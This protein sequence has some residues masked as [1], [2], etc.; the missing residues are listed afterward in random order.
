M[1]WT[2][3]LTALIGT[4]GIATVLIVLVTLTEKKGAAMLENAKALAESYKQLA[5]EYQQR[6]AKTQ[7][8]LEAKEGELLNQIKMNSSLRHALDDA[9][10][11]LAVTKLLRCNKTMCAER[12]PPFGSDADGVIESQREKSRKHLPSHE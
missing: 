5:D 2:Q 1:D 4:G 7:V 6:E 3:V 12:I 11:E 10:T 9:H 8:M